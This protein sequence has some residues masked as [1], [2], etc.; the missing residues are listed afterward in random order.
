MRYKE[1]KYYIASGSLTKNLYYLY[2]KRKENMSCIIDF[3][4]DESNGT[5]YKNISVNFKDGLLKIKREMNDAEIAKF[6]LFR[7]EN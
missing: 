5:I 1:G 6:T 2:I 7:M 3:Y 4:E